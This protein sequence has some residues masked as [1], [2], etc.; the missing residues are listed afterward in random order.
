[1]RLAPA[2]LCTHILVYATGLQRRVRRADGWR[3]HRPPLNEIRRVLLEREHKV[4]EPLTRSARQA[5]YL[6]QNGGGKLTP[7][8]SRRCKK[9]YR[10]GAW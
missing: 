7:R 8:Q 6:K 1:M 5:H 10:Q 3:P 4:T 9:K 2:S